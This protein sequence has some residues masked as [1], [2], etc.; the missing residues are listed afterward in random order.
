[1]SEIVKESS[2]SSAL[3]VDALVATSWRVL[4]EMTG[5]QTAV[6]EE[7]SPWELRQLHQE[8]AGRTRRTPIPLPR[9][10]LR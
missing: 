2:P 9:S 10:Q 4:G 1:M 6:G 8:P 3:A 7:R 5:I